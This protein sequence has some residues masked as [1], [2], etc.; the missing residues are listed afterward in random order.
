[1]ASDSLPS[2]CTHPLS[3]RFLKHVSTYC[4]SLSFYHIR[5]SFTDVWLSVGYWFILYSFTWLR[6][7][8]FSDVSELHVS[9]I[10]LIMP[11]GMSLASS[12]ITCLSHKMSISF[13]SSCLV[14]VVIRCTI[15]GLKW[16]P[17]LSLANYHFQEVICLST[18]LIDIAKMNCNS[19]LGGFILM[20]LDILVC[21]SSTS[22]IQP[23]FVS[24]W[25]S[26]FLKQLLVRKLSQCH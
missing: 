17:C 26:I 19:S 24:I 9:L 8:C 1:M 3:S 20:L 7:P 16:H 14:F 15:K 22:G 25:Y 23:V 13:V 5:Q 2:T 12:L 11:F 18:W 21:S 10:H 6:V 4:R